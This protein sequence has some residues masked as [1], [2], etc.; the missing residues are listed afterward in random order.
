MSDIIGDDTFSRYWGIL[1]NEVN[2]PIL[3]VLAKGVAGLHM[4]TQCALNSQ[5]M[6]LNIM[7]DRPRAWDPQAQ[8]CQNHPS[9]SYRG[10]I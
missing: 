6:I 4:V 2:N 10:Y 7:S 1:E 3:D 5:P 9:K 8:T